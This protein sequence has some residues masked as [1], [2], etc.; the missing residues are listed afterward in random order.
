[1]NCAMYIN[2]MNCRKSS[3]GKVSSKNKNLNKTVLLYR[4]SSNK[5]FQHLQNSE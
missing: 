1:M 3:S 5:V 4:C 2:F